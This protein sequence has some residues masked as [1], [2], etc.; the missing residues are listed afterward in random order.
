[1]NPPPRSF[2]ASESS[3]GGRR[4]HIILLGDSIIDNGHYIPEDAPNVCTQLRHAVAA[5]GWKVTQ[6]AVDGSLMEHVKNIQLHQMPLDA[7]VMVLS[8]G[9]NNGL[10]TLAHLKRAPWTTLT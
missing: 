8:V 6:L 2:S 3:M 1:M 5:R 10:H 7:T 4:E 9:G